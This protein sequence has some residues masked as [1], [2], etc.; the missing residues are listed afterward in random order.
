MAF[1]VDKFIKIS[2]EELAELIKQSDLLNASVIDKEKRISKVKPQF[3]G[4]YIKWIFMNENDDVVDF[5][6]ATDFVI[7]ELKNDG[8]RIHD[9]FGTI[10]SNGNMEKNAEISWGKTPNGGD[11]SILFYRFGGRDDGCEIVE[12]KRDGTF[13]Q[14]T[15]GFVRPVK[16]NSRYRIYDDLGQV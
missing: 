15:I 13:I 8:T 12:Y 4:D 3:D 1:I 14:S 2:N 16:P 7:L 10:K 11:Y 5:S 6:V 9:I